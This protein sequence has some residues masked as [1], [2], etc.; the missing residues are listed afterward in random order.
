M[1]S[2]ARKRDVDLKLNITVKREHTYK[3]IIF[4]I[5][6]IHLRQAS[7]YLFNSQ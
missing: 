3:L 7:E 5:I 1:E 2:I 4:S 6:I